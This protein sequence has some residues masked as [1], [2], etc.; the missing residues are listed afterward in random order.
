MRRALVV[1]ASVLLTRV[2]HAQPADETAP[3]EMP[4]EDK[5][6]LKVT[7][8][9]YV[10]SFYAL[11]LNF[12]SNR[13]TNHRGFD[14]RHNTF[15]L[16][17]VVLGANA[18]YGTIAARV[19][20]QYGLTPST[21]YLSEPTHSGTSAANA[22]SA[23]LW[24]YLQEAN[25]AW[26]APV[27]RGL[28][29]QM[30]LV[31]SPIGIEVFAVK[32]NW[33]W[34]R[35]NLFFGLPFY[36]A[37]IRATYEWTPELSSTFAVWNGWN[38][39]VDNNEE[40]SIQANV[41]YKLPNELQLQALYMGGVE[42]A[43]GSM[44]GP[45]WRHL[46]DVIGQ[47]DATPWFSIAA[48]ADYGFEPN[49]IGAAR[50]WAA[51]LYMRVRPVEKI[52][53]ALRADRFTEHLATSGGRSSAPLFWAGAEWVTSGTATLEARPHEHL[54]VRL[55]YRHDAAERAIYFGRNVT[56]DAPNART[57]DTVLLGATAW[58]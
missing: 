40:K 55:E 45:A 19:I 10:E 8:L 32:D 4:K 34:S 49:R 39:V 14:N 22:S 51:A 20:L 52:Y 15:S 12:P 25:V 18:E 46:F 36:H 23:E 29:L 42:R 11:N 41:N 57:Q 24:K 53:V 56:A 9:G 28:L 26:K 44:E 58:F 3:F 1:V 17:N 7:P 13:I 35:S 16:S 38:S 2:A 31:P 33:T 21:Y 27:G 43:T 37:G 47:Y 50:F 5:P 30:G 48:Q 54:S 6:V